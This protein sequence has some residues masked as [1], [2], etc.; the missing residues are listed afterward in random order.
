MKKTE[1][2]KNC[3]VSF[4]GENCLRMKVQNLIIYQRKGLVK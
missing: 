3:L 2:M 4:S 1:D